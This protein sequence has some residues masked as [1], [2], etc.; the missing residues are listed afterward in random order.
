MGNE[1]E[2]HV[3]ILFSFGIKAGKLLSTCIEINVYWTE[4]GGSRYIVGSSASTHR[5]LS[6]FI[7][8]RD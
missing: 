4:T 6:V 3:L 7:C 2:E 1:A 8:T 5:S